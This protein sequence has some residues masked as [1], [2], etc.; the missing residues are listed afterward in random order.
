M[1]KTRKGMRRSARHARQ[2]GVRIYTVG[3]GTREGE[4]GA[5]DQFSGTN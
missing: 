3:V 4:P 2:Q 5:G 1:V